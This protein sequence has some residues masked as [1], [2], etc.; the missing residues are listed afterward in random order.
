VALWLN[1]IRK[2]G[3]YIASNAPINPTPRI[4][5]ARLAGCINPI[6]IAVALAMGAAGGT[7][8]ALQHKANKSSAETS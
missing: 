7:V 2:G 3:G 1:D 4:F 6:P 8:A 5:G